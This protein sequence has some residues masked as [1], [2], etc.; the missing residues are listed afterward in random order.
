MTSRT[1]L[2]LVPLAILL[3]VLVPNSSAQ[4]P[5]G[6]GRY[7]VTVHVEAEHGTI[8]P[9]T[10]IGIAQI[11]IDVS[12]QPTSLETGLQPHH[13]TYSVHTDQP[14]AVV[15]LAKTSDHFSSLPGDCQKGISR[16]DIVQAEVAMTKDAPAY[17][18]AR[19]FFEARMDSG[20][21]ARAEW[22]QMAG[23]YERW[24][25]RF[26][27]TILKVG[28]NDQFQLP[29][30]I[31]NH[32]NGAIQVRTHIDDASSKALNVVTP[33]PIVVGSPL[34]GADTGRYTLAIDGRS[35]AE[36]GRTDQLVLRL[37]GGSAD[38]TS[39]VIQPKQLNAVIQTGDG[40]VD[41]VEEL[42]AASPVVMTLLALLAASV[43]RR[44]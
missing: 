41:P 40:S 28:P 14:W 17:A 2:M 5:L 24:Q 8:R 29:L 13:L 32:G 39:I 36:S 33:G 18:Q 35:P 3:L 42:P 21:P 15:R 23:F 26:D 30:V 10:D 38:D 19:I 16:T 12:C 1:V 11:R 34:A 22:V 37:T 27:Q 9:I 31:E 7:S 25:A 20:E 43:R 4:D 6:L 44:A